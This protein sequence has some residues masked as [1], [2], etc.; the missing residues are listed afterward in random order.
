MMSIVLAFCNHVQAKSDSKNGDGFVFEFYD[1]NKQKAE[2][3]DDPRL[4]KVKFIFGPG[5]A[6]ASIRVQSKGSSNLKDK[7]IQ[8]RW[9]AAMSISDE[10]PSA[11]LSDWKSA[12][13]PWAEITSNPD[14][15]YK[16][17][18]FSM[19]VF[20]SKTL[21][22]PK[23][24]KSELEKAAA[25]EGKRWLELAKQCKPDKIQ[26]PCRIQP[27][28]LEIKVTPVDNK[29]DSVLKTAQVMLEQSD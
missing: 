22:F 12:T 5:D 15:D 9:K 25:K 24:K 20:E 18:E 19:P 14:S 27:T 26:H 10:G 23:F 21:K 28:V 4:S 7:K 3:P 29:T 2:L 11:L 16:G 8:V 13:T 6:I 17:I 1:A